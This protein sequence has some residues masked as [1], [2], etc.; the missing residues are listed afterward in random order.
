MV[1]EAAATNEATNP[2]SSAARNA[3]ERAL[4]TGEKLAVLNACSDAAHVRQLLE[5][6]HIV[7]LSPEARQEEIR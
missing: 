5:S 3:L 4:A 6:G 1:E 2:V 7:M